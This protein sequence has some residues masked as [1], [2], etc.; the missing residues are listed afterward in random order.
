MNPRYRP[1]ERG[2]PT[3]VE[4]EGDGLFVIGDQMRAEDRAHAGCLAGALELDGAV[5]AVGVGAGQPEESPLGR[6]L[7]ERLGA[8][9]TDPEGEVGVNVEMGGYRLPFSVSRNCPRIRLNSAG[10]SSWIQ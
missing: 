7:R 4:G 6:R 1:A 9:G 3:R 8:R 5:D 10:W 2:P